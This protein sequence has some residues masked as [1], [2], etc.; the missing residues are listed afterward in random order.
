[1]G[2]LSNPTVYLGVATVLL[3]QAAFIYLPP[4]QTVFGSAPL[5][6]TDLVIATLVALLIVP[7]VT[8]EKRL[9]RRVD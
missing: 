2:L 3:A 5:S 8:L 4:L 7:V 1:M 6:W 9:L